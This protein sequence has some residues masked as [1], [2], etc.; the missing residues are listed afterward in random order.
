MD[1]N[2]NEYC[3]VSSDIMYDFNILEKTLIYEIIILNDEIKKKK[4]IKNINLN[5]ILERIT[6]RTKSFMDYTQSSNSE[7]EYSERDYD[8]ETN[9][10][11]DGN[12][13][14]DN[15]DIIKKDKNV[16][17]SS[18]QT[19][20]DN[21]NKA[22][23]KRNSNKKSYKLH[24]AYTEPKPKFNEK[25]EEICK[26]HNITADRLETTFTK[27]HN[28]QNKKKSYLTAD[29][30]EQERNI[31][32]EIARAAFSGKP[33]N[34]L[35][36]CRYFQTVIVEKEQEIIRNNQNRKKKR[37]NTD[38]LDLLDSAPP[39]KHINTTQTTSNTN[40][41]STTNISLNTTNNSTDTQQSL[42]TQNRKNNRMSINHIG[43]IITATGTNLKSYT[44]DN[45]IET[46]DKLQQELINYQID[47]FKHVSINRKGETFELRIITTTKEAT[48]KVI[49]NQSTLYKGISI[50]SCQSTSNR[51]LMK[52]NVP[53]NNSCNIND[54]K[55]LDSL[56]RKY[57]VLNIEIA[58]SAS[59][60][61]KYK[62][63]F[64]DATSYYNAY[65]KGIFLANDRVICTPYW[66]YVSFCIQCSEWDHEIGECPSNFFICFYCGEDHDG[67]KCK[68]NTSTSCKHCSDTHE[69][70]NSK[71][72]KY[73]TLFKEHNK[74]IYELL[75]N[76][77]Q[78]ASPNLK[79][80]IQIPRNNHITY[81]IKSTANPTQVK[82][83]ETISKEIGTV[84]TRLKALEDF[85][86]QQ[87]KSNNEL[88]EKI[89]KEVTNQVQALESKLLND[90]QS[91][92]DLINKQRQED[93]QIRNALL[94]KLNIDLGQNTLNQ[95]QYQQQNLFQQQYNHPQQ[96]TQQQFAS[97]GS[98][99]NHAILQNGMDTQPP[100]QMPRPG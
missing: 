53:R 16:R 33:T 93:V 20:S 97:T 6:K 58:Q 81:Q 54:V 87:I 1:C 50:I 28:I 49:S 43:S 18:M 90:N 84:T 4:P 60:I 63:E 34:K 9:D 68:N 65:T 96:P 56:R 24:N 47:E 36:L 12:E 100:P 89:T 94:S 17:N 38:E 27:I 73:I 91:T 76:E 92:R 41:V 83:L 71:C 64:V 80:E 48:E 10:E 3:K 2:K 85:K 52:C 13:S 59:K 22:R 39:A 95:Q 99:Q 19:K 79:L 5:L 98:F 8:G 86:E 7:D 31:I 40:S 72:S 21:V 77:N 51:L 29:F 62:I 25:I 32:R 70:F 46:R 57:G 37:S 78:K 45:E 82:N 14:N 11:E 67:T 23:S 75:E 74:F 30:S 15:D 42:T 88:G 66:R 35:N 44:S 26:K 55:E 61:K 69:T